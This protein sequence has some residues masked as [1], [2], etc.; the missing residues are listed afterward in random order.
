MFSG[1]RNPLSRESAAIPQMLGVFGI[2]VNEDR[3][4]LPEELIRMASELLKKLLAEL[5]EPVDSPP[6]EGDLESPDWSKTINRRYPPKK[7]IA[8]KPSG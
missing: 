3:V 1:R 6:V 2:L 4:T 8:D 7:A 5:D